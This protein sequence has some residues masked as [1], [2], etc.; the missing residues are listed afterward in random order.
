M[1]IIA[2]AAWPDEQTGERTYRL[3]PDE[4]F[5]LGDNSA[6]SVDSRHWP[7]GSVTRSLLIGRPVLLHLPSRRAGNYP[8][9]RIR[10]GYVCQIGTVSA[11]YDKTGTR[12]ARER[13]A[14]TFPATWLQFVRH[15]AT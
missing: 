10:P 12:N 9:G 1:Y 14:E 3:G 6:V 8:W 5:V 7:E 15:N 11:C 13:D 4:Y 2:A